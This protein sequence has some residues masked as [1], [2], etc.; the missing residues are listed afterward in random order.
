MPSARGPGWPEK[1]LKEKILVH[2]EP[3][4]GGRFFVFSVFILFLGFSVFMLSGVLGVFL[5]FLIL[6]LDSSRFSA[7]IASIF[8]E[9]H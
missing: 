5:L 7:S 6:F 1:R 9:K 2:P 8:V 3:P 4:S